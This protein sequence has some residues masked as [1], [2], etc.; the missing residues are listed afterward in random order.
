MWCI[1]SEAFRNYTAGAQSIATIAALIVGGIWTWRRFFQFREAKPKINL[2]LTVIFVRKQAGK[3]IVTVEALVE[4]KSKIR[5]Q[6]K[7]FTFDLRYVLPTDELD[8]QRIKSD[9]GKEIVLSARFPHVAA[10]GSW[11]DDAEEANDRMDYA[12]LEPEESDSWTF[13]ACIPEDATMI[14]ACAELYDER[15][16]E[17]IETKKVVTAP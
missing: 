17:S 6:F 11:L 3:W 9:G 12:A 15:S 5:H 8:N 2:N 4:N 1:N 13:I 14:E 7:D 10:R 16:K